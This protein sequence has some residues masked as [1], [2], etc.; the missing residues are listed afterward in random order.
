M[1]EDAT[2]IHSGVARSSGVGARISISERGGCQLRGSSPSD[3][4]P[5]PPVPSLTFPDDAEDLYVSPGGTKY[6]FL[7]ECRGL[8]NASKILLVPR[9]ENCGPVQSRPRGSLF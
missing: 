4:A 5:L 9:W 6:H 1:D 2:S 7:K 8:R 3:T